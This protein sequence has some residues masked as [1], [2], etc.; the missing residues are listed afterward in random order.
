MSRSTEASALVLVLPSDDIDSIITKIRGANTT[1]VQLLVPEGVTTLHSPQSCTALRHSLQNGSGAVALMIISSDEQTLKTARQCNLETI[2]VKDTHVLLPETTA[3]TA[4]PAIPV[5]IP[6]PAPRLTK[7]G[8][9]PF[10]A[11]LDD[12]SDI[13][14][15]RTSAALAADDYD[16]FAELDSL[17]DVLSGQVASAAPTHEAPTEPRRRIRPE[18]IVLSDEE[19][20]R[21]SSVGKRKPDTS[22][23]GF[24]LPF[25][26]TALIVAILILLLIVFGASLLMAGRTAITINLPQPVVQPFQAQPVPIIAVGGN[27]TEGAIRAEAISAEQTFTTTGQVIHQTMTPGSYAQGPI[28]LLNQGF[29]QMVIPAGT[30]FIGT[31]QAG[32]EVRFTINEPVVVP[33]ATSTRGDR[34]IVTDFGYAEATIVARA[35]GSNSNIDANTITL[36]VIPGQEPVA[37][38][39][40]VLFIEHGP[41]GGGQEQPVSIVTDA[42]VQ[43]A[44]GAALTG[45]NDQ[46]YQGLETAASSRGLVLEKD[47]IFP[48]PKDLESG[49]GFELFIT[50]ALGEMTYAPD[51]TFSVVVRA[52]FVALMTPKDAPLKKQAQ[53]VLP[54]QLVNAGVLKPEDQLVPTVSAWHW[55]GSALLV[56]GTVQSPPRKDLDAKTRAAVYNAV[57]GK[58]RAEAAA[59]LEQLKKQGRISGY[60]LPNV[61]KL[62]LW[63]FQ[64][65]LNEIPATQ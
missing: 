13:M 30:D 9:D 60:A 23:G 3:T 17:G 40:G 65:T 33:P 15:G 52:R 56:D 46:A 16:P 28:V 2:A 49:A 34:R 35:P 38:N 51:A 8:D 54:V 55:D 27:A 41:I 45:L 36:F 10:A 7:G 14:G 44:L 11:D 19:K 43:P 29:Q 22:S 25:S 50:P 4:A 57:K 53:T 20:E 42:D 31:N 63:D 32:Q 37:A 6:A 59:A 39:S 21:A 5:P 12:L 62:P 61:E 58:T 47:T 48:S 24:A 64:I 18:D 1:S 26:R